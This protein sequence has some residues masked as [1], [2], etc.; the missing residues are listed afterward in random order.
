MIRLSKTKTLD[1]YFI[2]SNGI[3][4]DDGGNIQKTKTYKSREFFKG[5]A[6]HQIQMFTNYGFNDGMVIHHIDKNP[7]N[8][9]LSNLVYITQNEHVGI[10]NHDKKGFKHSEETK[11]LYSETRK[12]KTSP[13]KGKHLSED[14]KEKLR[15]ACKGNNVG[16]KNGMFGK[17]PK[18][19]GVRYKWIN[20]GIEQRYVPL[21]SEIPVGFQ[22]GMLKK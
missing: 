2:D 6:V 1:N 8:N 10:H 9:S 14:Q 15:I 18:N 21:D 3:I 5:V 12:G 11:R 20:N 19:K 13:N 17:S 4:T 16:E 7:L 22:R